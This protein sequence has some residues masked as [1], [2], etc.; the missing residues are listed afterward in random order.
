[1]RNQSIPSIPVVRGST[2]RW[3]RTL[4]AAALLFLLV[5][6]GGGKSANQ[7]GAASAM[8]N[9]GAAERATQARALDA[10]S[11]LPINARYV[12]L[13]ALSEVNGNPWTSVAEFNLLDP[14]G[15]VLSRGGWV[16]SADSQE[17]VGEY[18]PAGHAIDGDPDSFWH[19][20]WYGQSPPL[21]HALTV[22]L[23]SPQNIGGFTYL[24][25]QIGENGRIAS[26]SFFTST[27]GVNWTLAAQGVFPK[28]TAEQTVMLVASPGDAAPILVP[29]NDR[30]DPLG[31]ALVQALLAT[32]PNNLALT[33]AATGL[34]DGLALDPSTGLISGTA[35]RA[36]A[37]Q[38][39]VQVSDTQGGA[40]SGSFVWT[41]TT[42]AA[43]ASTLAR[44][45]R[46]QALSEVNGNPWTSVAE[47]NLLDPSGAKLPRGGWTVTA[48]SQEL[49]GENA[50][51]GH[52]VDGDPN[53][54]WHTQWYGAS[55]PLPHA[56]TVDLG[57]PQYI[58]GFTYLPRQIGQNGRIAGWNFFTSTDGVNWTLFAQGSFVNS[59]AE[60]S[61]LASGPAAAPP[62]GPSSAARA[63]RIA[64][65]ASGPLIAASP[66]SA[67]LPVAANTVLRLASGLNLLYVNAG[68]TGTLD[69]SLLGTVPDGRPVIDG[70]AI[71]YVNGR[72]LA[73]TQAGAPSVAWAPSASAAGLVQTNFSTGNSRPA[74]L[75]ATQGCKSIST[76]TAFV[77]HYCFANGPSSGSG[78]ATAYASGPYG[79]GLS[80][81]YVYHANTWEEEFV[82]TDSRFGIVFFNSNSPIDIEVDGVPL[83][84]SPLSSSGAPGWTLTLDYGGVVKQRVIRVISAVGAVAPCLQGVALSPGGQVA[85]GT[86]SNDQFLVLG[87]SIN[88]TV[89]PTSEAGA[90]MMS[91]WIQRDLGFGGAINMAVGGS[92]Y[93]SEN[94]GSFNIPDLLANPVNQALLAS[95]AP[96]ISH[97][98]VGAG[99]NDRNQPVATVTANAL[100]SWQALRRLLPNA[101]ISI[102][103]GWS[104]S[105]GPDANALALASALSQTFQTW[106]DRN[107]RLIH[108]IGSS[109]ATA[110]VSGTGNAGLP[111]TAG[112]SSFYTSVDAV[113]PSPA[114]ARYLARRLSN[115]IQSAWAGAY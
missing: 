5:A 29:L 88:A 28:G 103:D 54:F 105:S 84:M 70:T 86:V 100:A 4:G 59:A 87:D 83:Q 69:P 13:Q 74:Y 106:G 107:A 96:S 97:V 78:N 35:T 61:Y 52:A 55:P 48:D 91:Y 30:G 95:Y 39:A 17:L 6:C 42:P 76:G 77:G 108:S 101:K 8:S 64:A 99:F 11:A 111:V 46:L 12:R 23:G 85:A 45:V 110:Y 94:P 68:T 49:V 72:L 71:A 62:A 80:P 44:Y 98:I 41:I 9:T 32:D 40:A 36:G 65:F 92:G 81:A 33:Y 14:S 89:V 34:P 25:R 102:T 24:P 53:S 10:S 73:A 21:P 50:P 20:Q 60:Q 114:G 38:V 16:V 47:F 2:G 57:S 51:V 43:S 63:A 56:L 3:L 15:A 67:G 112:N 66:W 58:G 18:A 19:T 27:D 26:W 90:Q 7:G 31:S 115:D 79:A 113:H 37:F 109:T 1:M 93:V 22:D 82:V 75:T 104:G